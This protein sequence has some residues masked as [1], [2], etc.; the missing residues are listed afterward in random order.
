MFN[1]SCLTLNNRMCC[2]LFCAGTSVVRSTALEWKL[3]RVVL[4]PGMNRNVPLMCPSNRWKWF[5][6][7]KDTDTCC[8]S[9]SRYCVLE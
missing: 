4:Q 5:P 1:I 6:D 8:L 2:M 3:Y 9:Y 7:R